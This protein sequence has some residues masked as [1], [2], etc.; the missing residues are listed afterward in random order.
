MD[1]PHECLRSEGS[2]IARMTKG[3]RVG[4]GLGLLSVLGLQCR[5]ELAELWV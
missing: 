5:K 3:V 4:L 2:L 1:E